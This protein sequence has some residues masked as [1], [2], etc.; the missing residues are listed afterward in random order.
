[1]P[2]SRE[3]ITTIAAYEQEQAG[4]RQQL[5]GG[6]YHNCLQM[7]RRYAIFQADFEPG[8]RFATLAEQFAADSATAITPDEIGELVTAME[9]IV[10]VMEIVET[11]TPGIFAIPIQEKE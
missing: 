3:E 1:M 2:L 11:R 5:V 6:L 4:I 10:S 9:T 7:L 8:G